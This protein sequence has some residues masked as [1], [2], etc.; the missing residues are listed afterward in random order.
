MRL[1]SRP[2]VLCLA[3]TLLALMLAETAEA[4]RRRRRPPVEEPPPEQV[5]PPP[6]QEPAPG[7]PTVQQPAGGGWT[8]PGAPNDPGDQGGGGEA[9]PTDEPPVE[10]DSFGTDLGPLRE[11]FTALM[12]EL[13]QTRSRISVLGRQLFQT[14]IRVTLQNRA[15]DQT[16]AAV[17]IRLDGASV[18]RADGSSF[19]GEDGEQVFEGFAAPGPHMVTV[20]AEQRGRAN[21]Q[22]RYTLRDSF[23]FE[24]LR[25][26]LTEVTIVLDDD[27]DMAE[28]FPD[29]EEGE[30]DV[31]TRVRVATRELGDR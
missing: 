21:D 17:A 18:F 7:D 23:R 29:D 2:L 10:D 3:G 4:Q 19:A 9:P 20:E 24:V 11:E 13:V 5:E 8:V 6:P 12:D 1:P 25:G 15:D 16:L 30:Y 27:S 31:R 28:D 22:F 14:K 26:K